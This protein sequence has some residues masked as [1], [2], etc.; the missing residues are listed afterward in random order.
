[1]FIDKDK[2][3]K[4]TIENPNWMKKYKRGSVIA[5]MVGAVF[6]WEY[7]ARAIT[8]YWDPIKQAQTINQVCK[9]GDLALDNEG[10]KWTPRIENHH[11]EDAKRTYYHSPDRELFFDHSNGKFYYTPK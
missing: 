6:G 10:F 5:A 11:D 3:R 1:M 9:H 4:E 7:S 8:D 2:L